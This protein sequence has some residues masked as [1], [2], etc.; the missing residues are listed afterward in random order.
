[1]SQQASVGWE[2]TSGLYWERLGERSARPP[3]LFIHGGGCTGAC[4]RI[5]PD[6]RRGWA[7]LAAERGNECW[8]TDWPGSGRSG[9]TEM[10]EV[11]YSYVVAGYV[12]LLWDIIAEPVVVLCHSMGGPVAWKLV[13][14]AGELVAGVIAVA[15]AQ[16]G[17]VSAKGE[18]RLDDGTK[19]TV[20]FPASGVDFTVRRDRPYRYG[21]SYLLGQGIATSKRFPW[22]HLD[23]QRSSSV[24]L[25]PRL[26]IQRLGYDGGLPAVEDPSKFAGMW[27]RWIAGPEDPAHTLEIESPAIELLTS[28]GAD[29]QM[30][31]LPDRGIEGNGHFLMAENNSDEILGLIATEVEAGVA[32]RV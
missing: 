21:D 20:H 15:A 3:W 4:F 14:E 32:K 1:M 24:P 5:T 10:L 12:R 19:I 26:A 2:T 23:A 25:S 6:G 11:D 9:R 18:V 28:W 8:V 7:E 29:A 22:E 31:W 30:V 13:E 27:V 17:N 16:P